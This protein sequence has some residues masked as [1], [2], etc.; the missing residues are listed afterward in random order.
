MCQ[1]EVDTEACFNKTQQALN[2]IYSSKHELTLK[3]KS[4]QM[5]K[6]MIV[7]KVYLCTNG[8]VS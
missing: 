8:A 2:F 4:D 1:K 7:V 3:L 5:L 6:A